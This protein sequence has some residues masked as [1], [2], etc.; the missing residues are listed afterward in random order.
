[1]GSAMGVPLGLAGIWAKHAW[2]REKSRTSGTIL[3][4][5]LMGDPPFLIMAIVSSK[6]LPTS[7]SDAIL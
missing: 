5:L 4:D 1:M 6:I 2:E 3:S 7:L